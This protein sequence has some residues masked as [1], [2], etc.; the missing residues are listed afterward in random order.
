MRGGRGIFYETLFTP[1]LYL[2]S[3]ILHLVSCGSHDPDSTGGTGDIAFK[4][5]WQNAPTSSK[6]KISN[7]TSHIP[8]YAPIDCTASN[9]ST[10]NATVYSSSGSS[11]ATGGP[12]N[13]SAHS[14]S[15]TS[16]PAGSN[17]KLTVL[18]KDSS[19]NVKYMG[20]QTGIT[21]EDGK[22]SPTVTVTAT[23]FV[24]T[25]ISASAGNG[26]VSIS[27]SSV[28]GATSYN[29]Y[30]STTSGVTKNNGSKIT[31]VTSPYTHTGRTNGTT[32]YYV[33]TAVNSCL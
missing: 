19:G 13:C 18:G 23:S 28:S 22:T 1:Y 2:V 20:E 25:G 11:L 4:I 14:G 32:Y 7:P 29:I 3:C 5:D 16:V 27:W 21:V 9:V 17:R 24:P 6:S 33:V 10:V 8:S 12:W 26:Q 15:I 30:W 31:G